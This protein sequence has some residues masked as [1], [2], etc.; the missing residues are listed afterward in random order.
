MLCFVR[1]S[2]IWLLAMAV[3][4]QA[5]AAATFAFCGSGHQGRAVHPGSTPDAQ[6]RH[7]APQ[8]QD[9]RVQHSVLHAE[10]V[11]SPQGEHSASADRMQ[12]DS[13]KCSACASCC[14]ALA[15]VSAVQ[16]PACPESAATLFECVAPPV[17]TSA[18]DSPDRPPRIRLA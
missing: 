17:E 11:A 1:T 3:P 13:H 15:L 6:H 18:A 2:L 8:A 12:A 14:S 9:S 16:M 5:V 7:A 4:A 10:G